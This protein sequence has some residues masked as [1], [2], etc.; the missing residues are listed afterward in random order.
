[1]T[2][3]AIKGMTQMAEHKKES[4]KNQTKNNNKLVQAGSKS[5]KAKQTLI[6]NGKAVILN[7]GTIWR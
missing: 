7:L 2:I 1:V 4:N 5:N 6:E 3:R